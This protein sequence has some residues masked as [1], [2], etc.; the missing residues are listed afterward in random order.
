MEHDIGHGHRVTAIAYADDITVIKNQPEM[1][2]W[3]NHLIWYESASSNRSISVCINPIF[4]QASTE[5]LS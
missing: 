2:D 3:I 4:P 5:D 1:V